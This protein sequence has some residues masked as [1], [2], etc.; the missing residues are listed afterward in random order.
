VLPAGTFFSP[1]A[2]TVDLLKYASAFGPLHQ[3]IDGWNAHL[4]A[5]VNKDDGAWH[6]SLTGAYD[7]NDL[8]TRTN[9][10]VDIT[11]VQGLVSAGTLNPYAPLTRSGIVPTPDNTARA[12]SDSGNLQLSANGSIAPLPAGNILSSVTLGDTIA[13]LDSSSKTGG[14]FQASTLTRN[15]FNV[16]GS[17]D[18]PILSARGDML[19]VL[20]DVSLNINGALDVLSDFGTL[21]SYG[22][23][24]Y[25]TPIPAFKVIASQTHD[26]AAPSQQQLGNPV[27]T[28]PNQQVFDYALGQSVSV[29]QTTGGNAGLV[30]DQ[31]T[32][33]KIGITA[34]PIVSQNLTVTAD[35]IVSDIKNAIG[36][37]PAASLLVEQAFPNRF[38]RNAAGQLAQIDLRPVNFAQRQSSLF[39]LGVSWADTGL[40]RPPITEGSV[41]RPAAP[42]PLPAGPRF[43]ADP[44]GHIQ[45][46][47]YDTIYFTDTILPQAGGPVLDLL[48]GAAAGASGGQPRQQ[49]Q[50]QLGYIQ[51]GY[52]FRLSANWTSGTK[53]KGGIPTSD[54]AFSGLVTVNVGAFVNFSGQPDL[55]QQ[56]PLLQGARLSLDIVN[57]FDQRVAARDA[58]GNT[59]ISLQSPYFDPVGRYIDVK[60][61][62]LFN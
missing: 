30:A 55:V 47:L 54:L 42:P 61:R 20:G 28:V 16:H 12:L 24:L 34:T 35:Y 29:T 15:D 59:P 1:F 6:Y 45:F 38:I 39:R 57:L 22:Y 21:K 52:G 43:E 58:N 31:R 23:G 2:S 14:K 3:T 4:G 32:L 60:L 27:V 9:A 44:L 36:T 46:A 11:A 56:Y 8:D 5:T 10:G 25:W 37:L 33:S 17:L 19:P 48:N 7:H 51:Q 26:Q 53:V 40:F 62:K 49:I 18:I 41:A 50:A 13:N